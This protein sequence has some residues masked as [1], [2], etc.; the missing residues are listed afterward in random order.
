VSLAPILESLLLVPLTLLP[1]INPLG[2]APIFNATAGTGRQVVR[3][4]AWQVAV[5]S[6]VVLVVSMLV[7]IYVLDFFGISLQIVRLGG[8]LL[9]AAMGWRTL[10]SHGD[11]EVR[12]AVAH[13]AH[14]LSDSEIARQSFFPLTFP[15]TTGPGSISAAIALGVHL[16]RQ[17]LQ[18]L[19]GVLV[20]ALGA[21]IT[22]AAIYL[23][24]RHS[25]K[26]L[27]KLGEIGTL[28][29]MRL[30]AFIL[31]CIGIE[32]MWTGWAALNHIR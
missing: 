15:L 13:R 28:V 26:L 3:K 14:D 25:A 24:Y 19:V 22:S 7:G 5:N 16:P 27:A 32:I 4:F 6:W 30:F 9:V 20:A 11:D 21:A 12:Q 23:C 10:N 18:Y 2:T 17:P 8:G 29:I 1:I 31:L